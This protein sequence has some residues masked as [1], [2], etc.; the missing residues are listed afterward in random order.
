M[1]EN[2]IAAGVLDAPQAPPR[3]QSAAPLPAQPPRKPAI[4]RALAAVP[5][6]LILGLLGA[7]GWWGHHTGWKLPKFSQ[8]TGNGAAEKDDWCA[9][10]SVPDSECVECN[11]CLMPR[12]KAVTWCRVHGVHECPFEHPEVVQMESPPSITPAMLERARRA[13]AFMDRSYNN[14]KCKLHQ[15]RIQL[16]GEAAVKKAGIDV[17]PVWEAPI[18]EALTAPGEITYDQ[19]LVANLSPPVPGRVW[20]VYK[21]LG[22]TV[23]KGDVLAL[24]DA[25]EVGKT[26]AD[27]VSAA[28]LVS[29]RS[30]RLESLKPLVGT[31]VAEPTY[32]EAQGA[33]RE[34]EA[35][36]ATAEQA[37]VNFGLPIRAEDLKGMA[38]QDMN[39]H[40]QFL[41]LPPE[42]VRTLGPRTTPANLIPVRA[43]F[44]GVVVARKVVAGEQV[45]SSKTL[46]VVADPRQLWLTLH[47]RQEEAR[48]VRARDEAGTTRGQEVRFRSEAIPQ[49]VSGEVVWLSTAVDERTRTVQVRAN[50]PN[51]NGLLRANVF[52]TGKIILR[53]EKEAVVVPNESVQWEGDC[54]VVFVRDKDY[55]KKGAR[56]VFH[57]RTVRIG[58]KDQSNT[59]IIAGVL[60]G[61]VV[62]TKGAG[63]LRSELLKNNLGAG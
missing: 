7:V 14:S 62:V 19:T 3:A 60:P 39:R 41:G 32:V 57:T 1:N 61:E 54:H 8:L 11:A 50:L 58:A 23:R 25:A 30:Q 47:V 38:P 63:V 24:V 59:E 16:A 9:E 12:C 40:V 31:S 22:Q 4:R 49:E 28:S 35:R 10:H 5:N 37:L 55:F 6:L 48:F 2:V 42:L 53:E 46:F 44:D 33:L 21:Q 29:L 15:R 26:K 36:L 13:L 18:T 51:P 56:K 52:G 27:L 20:H 34:A 43:P 45:D 17:A